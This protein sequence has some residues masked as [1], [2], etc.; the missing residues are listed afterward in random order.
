MLITKNVEVK[1][2][3]QNREHY[4]K[5]GYKF[6][7]YLDSFV[8]KIEDSTSQSHVEVEMIC[9]NCNK[10]KMMLPYREYLKR[11][12]DKTYFCNNCK[13]EIKFNDLKQRFENK[14]YIL[15]SD[16]SEYENVFSYVNYICKKHKEKGVMKILVNSFN[17]GSGCKYCGIEKMINKNKKS[18]EEVKELF[19]SKNLILLTDNYESAN[20]LLEFICGNHKDKGVQKI[21]YRAVAD[22]QGCK[23]CGYERISNK[24]KHNYDFVKSE[25]EKRNYI[26]LDKEYR[27]TKNKLKYICKK[28]PNEIQEIE[29]RA[30]YNQNQG[31]KFCALEKVSGENSVHWKGGIS[32]LSAYLRTF[33]NDWKMES[34]KKCDYKCVITGKKSNGDFEVHHL[35]SVDLIIQKIL[36]E[37]NMELKPKISDYSKDELE[38]LKNLFIKENNKLH[39]VVLDPKI[40]RL[41]HKIYGYGK[42]TPEQF[43]EFKER[44]KNGEFD[45][46]IRE[47]V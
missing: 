11:Y 9:D 6:T 23:Y 18:Y 35:L 36:S 2:C 24:M 46:M 15:V 3:K 40:H 27:G 4:E 37:I 17:N 26:L 21:R 22:G 42:N 13:K 30:L 33:L 19:K 20:Q 16:I 41:Y 44:Y 28:H 14:G 1:W 34:F 5:L 29:F 25:F 12:K 45:E 43:E 10:T 38:I 47:V 8:V 7:K 39:G 31:C 32:S